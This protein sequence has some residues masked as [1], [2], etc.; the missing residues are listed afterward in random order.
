MK[1]QSFKRETDESLILI[2]C[3]LEEHNLSLAL[4]TG[5][6]HT[7]IDLAAMIIAGYDIA[8]SIRTVQLETASGVIDA[9]VFRVKKLSAIGIIRENVEVCAYDFF[10]FQIITDFD[11]VLGLDFLDEYKL[12]IDFKND[13]L[14]IQ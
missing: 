1:Q 11:G 10:S 4:D 8:K 2:N 3:I 9:Y 6:S 12:C 13:L 7:T 14:T 5:A